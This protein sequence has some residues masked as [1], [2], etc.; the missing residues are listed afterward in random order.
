MNTLIDCNFLPVF[1]AYHHCKKTAKPLPDYDNYSNVEEIWMNFYGLGKFETYQFVYQHCSGIDHFREWLI[2]L[3]GE[4]KIRESAAAFSRWQ[5]QQAGSVTTNAPNRILSTE[6]LNSWKRDGYLRI[7]DL[8]EEDLCDAV[9]ALICSHM[10]IDLSRPAT[11]YTQHPDWHG[12]MVLLY[13]GESTESIRSHPKLKQLFAELYDTPHIIAKTEK[14]SFNPPETSTWKFAHSELHWDIDLK[15]DNL[16]YIQGLV[17]LNDVPENRGPLK[18]VPGFHSKFEKFI[19]GYPDL[20]SATQAMLR[21]VSAIPVPGKK[22]DVVLWLQ[23]LPHAASVNRSDMPRF[24]QYVSFSKL[25][26]G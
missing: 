7:S 18:L 6:Q 15:K 20:H 16:Y 3:K 26:I 14:V 24:V 5:Q 12:L 10:H 13:Q 17:Y 8:I 19:A 23:T 2:Q 21:S 25:E 1:Y 4:K 11:W 9:V 22:G